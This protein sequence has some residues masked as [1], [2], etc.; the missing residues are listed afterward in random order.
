MVVTLGILGGMVALRYLRL[1]RDTARAM[2]VWLTRARRRLTLAN[3]RVERDELAD[4]LE[5]LEEGM[6][7]PGSVTALGA[8]VPTEEVPPGGRR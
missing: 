4:A 3:L 2:R 1:L 8:V 7:L 6:D 5:A